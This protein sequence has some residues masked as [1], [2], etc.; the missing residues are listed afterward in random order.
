MPLRTSA[1]PTAAHVVT[2]AAEALRFAG[3]HA[4][5]TSH[6]ALYL[7]GCHAADRGTTHVL[8]PYR[9]RVRT[10]GGLTVHHGSVQRRDVEILYGLRVLVLEPALAEVLCRGDPYVAVSC[11]DQALARQPSRQG[12]TERVIQ[13]VQ[14]RADPR[15]RR[16]AEILLRA[17]CPGTA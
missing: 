12:F 4:V 3:P 16:E 7:Y 9:R 13:A 6:T 10:R 17:R 1:G 11:L 8:V 5:L 14:A 15:G 2:A